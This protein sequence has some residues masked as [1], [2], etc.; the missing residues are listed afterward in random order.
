[1]G[2]SAVNRHGI[3]WEFYIVWRVVTLCIFCLFINIRLLEVK[4]VTCL[5]I[6][7]KH[8]CVVHLHRRSS[9]DIRCSS[10]CTFSANTWS[11]MKCELTSDAS[12]YLLA[13]NLLSLLLLPLQGRVI[14]L[15]RLS[16]GLFVCQQNCSETCVWIFVKF[17]EGLHIGTRN[18]RLDFWVTWI[19]IQDVAHC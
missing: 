1:M 17:L 9:N 16:V 6:P 2:R 4:S 3:V 13:N 7:C 12:R 10:R 14:S 18:N 8:Y 11:S 5:Y 15:P 19:E